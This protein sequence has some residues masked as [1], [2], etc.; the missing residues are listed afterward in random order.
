MSLNH[1]AIYAL[2]PQVVCVDDSGG[3]LD[4]NGKKVNIDLALVNSWVDPEKYKSQ[5]QLEYP[6]IE[7]QLDTLYHGGLAEWKA[8]IKAVK[9]KYPKP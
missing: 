8:S 2:Y 3:A 9:D 7:E 5:R 1:R 6:S 4:R